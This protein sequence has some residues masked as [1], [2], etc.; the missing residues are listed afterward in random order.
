MSLMVAAAMLST[1]ASTPVRRTDEFEGKVIRVLD[2]RT[3][4]VHPDQEL[5]GPAGHITLRLFGIVLPATSKHHSELARQFLRRLVLGKRVHA[6]ILRG[7][8]QSVQC[9][10][11]LGERVVNCEILKAAGH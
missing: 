1:F 8:R 6:T 10:V 11:F 4:N 9:M 3:M 2:G 7:D 5:H